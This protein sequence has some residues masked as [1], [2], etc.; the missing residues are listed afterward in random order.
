M[1]NFDPQE[2]VNTHPEIPIIIHVYNG[3]VEG[4]T[5]PNDQLR[6]TILDRDE[7]IEHPECPLCFEELDDNYCCSNCQFDFTDVL[8]P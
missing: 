7:Y 2:Y 8:K 3:I 4:V 6:Y 5:T 1:K